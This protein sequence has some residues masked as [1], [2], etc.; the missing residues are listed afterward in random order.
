M[1]AKAFL[2]NQENGVT[3]SQNSITDRQLMIVRVCVCV[4]VC[5]WVLFKYHAVLGMTFLAKNMLFPILKNLFPFQR[6]RHTPKPEITQYHL[7][8]FFGLSQFK[9]KSMTTCD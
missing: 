6:W 8:A 4:C 5:V 1:N 2:P 9:K 7:I 3:H